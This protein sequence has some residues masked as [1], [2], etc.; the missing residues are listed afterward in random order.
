[1]A[2]ME[3]S[4]K[5][6]REVEFGGQLR[7]YDTDE[8]DEF[9]EQVAIA[10]EQLQQEVVELKAR[11]EAAEQRAERCEGAPAEVEGSDAEELRRLLLLAQRAA[12]LARRDAEREVATMRERARN[13]VAVLLAEGQANVERMTTE[14]EL[15]RREEVVRLAN[16]RDRLQTEIAALTSLVESERVRLEKG[17][18]SALRWVER[19]L[20]P[21]AKVAAIRS[22]MGTESKLGQGSVRDIEAEI[23]EDAA[24]AAP[25]QGRG[26]SRKASGLHDGPDVG[27]APAVDGTVVPGRW[28]A[29]STDGADDGSSLENDAAPEETASMPPNAPIGPEAPSTEVWQIDEP[30]VE[31]IH[32]G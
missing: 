24:A 28:A 8:V 15:S 6:L 19:S 16:E 26:A 17:L 9:L 10:V 5:T 3:I 31:E 7:G 27:V 22:T 25:H 29:K 30:A 32:Q 13:E 18:R 11:L 12:D 20:T 14:A 21:S 1:M 2:A 4:A 23:A